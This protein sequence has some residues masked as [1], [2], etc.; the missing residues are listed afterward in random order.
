MLWFDRHVETPLTEI[1]IGEKWSFGG[2]YARS[3]CVGSYIRICSPAGSMTISTAGPLPATL[4]QR[5][6]SRTIR[7]GPSRTK[8]TIGVQ[9]DVFE[10]VQGWLVHHGAL[11][12]HP[13]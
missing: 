10:E 9:Y 4:L 12:L 7:M 6:D 1:W 5:Y 8:F 11:R 13:G 3:S 2:E